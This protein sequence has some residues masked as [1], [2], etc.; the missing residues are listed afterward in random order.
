MDQLVTY[1]PV[2]NPI[3]KP[4]R[5]PEVEQITMPTNKNTQT[6]TTTSTTNTPSIADRLMQFRKELFV[7]S[8]NFLPS[9]PP[10]PGIKG[11]EE[12]ERAWEEYL[13]ID[14]D[15]AKEK[16]LLTELASF[17][18]S[19]ENVPSQ[20]DKGPNRAYGYFQVMDYNMDGLSPQ[21][22]MAN[23]VKQ[24]ELAV[25]LL[26]NQRKSFTPEDY[27]V[28]AQKNLSER[29]LD[30]MAWF[31]GP[32]SK[33]KKRGVKGYL[34]HGVD[35][36]DYSSYGGKD[37]GGV[38]MTEYLKRVNKA[39]DGGSLDKDT[40][41]IEIAGNKY[42]IKIA[43]TDEEKS[44]GLSNLDNLP[45]KEGMLFLINEDEKDE[46]G[47]VWFTMEDT[48]FPLD[49]IFINEDLEVVQVSKG[50]PMSTEPIYGKG[51]YVLELNVNSGVKV[52]D[53]LEFISDKEVNKK[54]LVLDP[55][56]NVQMTLDGG[57]RIMSINNTKTLI[58]F[59][60]KA[61][62][63]KKDNDYKALGKR[64]FKFLTVQDNTEP[65]YV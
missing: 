27:A 55:E 21:E 5:K 20:G 54:M 60:K 63:T 25:K 3:K 45:A 40:K 64:V 2:D 47:R 16:D 13:K 10:K 61:S 57:E 6:N 59:A 58:K 44:V 28:A 1:K 56:G 35:P 39:K 11:P 49:I 26:R 8:E 24:I 22:F 50:E 46:E 48:K 9:N 14:P 53:E 43:E 32:G 34:Y 51:D 37:K 65:E 18:S 12:Y 38:T 52:N 19:Y 42:S 15:A 7:P 17:E 23:P 36:N 4:V 31:A 41:Y 30:K 62:E 33:E 29:D